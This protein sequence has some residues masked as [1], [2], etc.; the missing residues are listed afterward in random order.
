MLCGLY[1]FQVKK[2]CPSAKNDSTSTESS[3]E[4]STEPSTESSTEPE[5]TSDTNAADKVGKRPGKVRMGLSIL[6]VDIIGDQFW[7]DRP[8]LLSETN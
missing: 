3:T 5:T 1:S 7:K 8:H 6:H 4:S 2:D